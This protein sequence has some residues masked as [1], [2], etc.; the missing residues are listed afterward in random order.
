MQ[1][2]WALKSEEKKIRISG[3]KDEKSQVKSLRDANIDIFLYFKRAKNKFT[4]SHNYFYN[5]LS[6]NNI[7]ELC[8]ILLVDIQLL[9]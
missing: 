3:K 1:L 2:F 9:I 5:F 4:E 6:K 7:P 8:I